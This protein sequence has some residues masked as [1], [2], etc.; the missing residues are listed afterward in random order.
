MMT[1]RTLDV[2]GKGFGKAIDRI[3]G[4]GGMRWFFGE[5]RAFFEYC[6][7]ELCL[8]G[9]PGFEVFVMTEKMITNISW[10]YYSLA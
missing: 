4:G 8:E 3:N 7:I 9:C 5:G 1:S 2:V 10:I 6:F